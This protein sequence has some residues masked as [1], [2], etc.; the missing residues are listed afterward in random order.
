MG[1]HAQAPHR[2][3]LAVR[4]L[5]KLPMKG[6]SRIVGVYEVLDVQGAP[7]QA[8]RRESV[9]LFEESRLA[10][11][12]GRTAEALDGFQRILDRDPADRAAGYFLSL[13]EQ[14]V[15]GVWEPVDLVDMGDSVF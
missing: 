2:D 9:A 13:L 14:P 15:S 8:A 11:E 12:S 7:E 5:G 6:R 1:F 3:T 4:Y 10:M